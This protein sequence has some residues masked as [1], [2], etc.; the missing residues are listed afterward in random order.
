MIEQRVV[1]RYATA[2]F[3]A[4]TKAGVVDRVESDLGL[5]SFVVETSPA[6]MQAVRSPL[7]PNAK[8]HD[9]LNAIFGDKVHKITLSYL[10]L[11]VDKRREEA[12]ALTEQEYV[13]LANDARGIITA[14]VVSAVK[15]SQ[16]EENA[17]KAKITAMTGKS[18]QLEKTVDTGIIGGITVRIGDT[19]HDGS[20]KGQLKALRDRLLAD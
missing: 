12:I 8:K 20:I 18:V 17:I 2:V 6:L 7:V 9:V 5:V 3:N 11:L 16:D 15:L 4:A 19:V 14:Q 10:L 13:D 1:R